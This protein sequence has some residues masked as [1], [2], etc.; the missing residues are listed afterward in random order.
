MKKL[1]L[2]LVAVFSFAG[3]YA[4]EL[5]DYIYTATAKYKVIDESLVQPITAWYGTDDPDTWSTYEEEGV[6]NALQSL[7]GSEG[8]TLL[9]TNA[10]L[11]F[12]QRYIVT[13]KIK[14]VATTVS[15]VTRNQRIHHQW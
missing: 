3:A 1:L 6:T 15:S 12:G 8:T 7:D 13:L 14:G 2:S 10:E 5:G 4:Y 9:R 11:T